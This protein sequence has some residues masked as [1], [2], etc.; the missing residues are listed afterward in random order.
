MNGPATFGDKWGPATVFFA[1]HNQ[2]PCGVSA[3]G[4][5][6]AS[7]MA[8]FGMAVGGASLI[9]W[10]LMMRLQ[11]RRRNR[12]SSGASFEAG[13]GDFASG[14]GWSSLTWFSGH[15]SATDCSGNPADSAGGDS[16]GGCCGGGDGGS[17]GD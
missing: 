6:M 4:E 1:V 2:A 17:G 16:G 12:P 14:D 10:A 11:N 8:A 7:A 9:C 3:R 5:T 15:H 13:G